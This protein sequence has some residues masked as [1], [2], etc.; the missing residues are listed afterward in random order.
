MELRVALA[1]AGSDDER[2]EQVSLLLAEEL[3]GLDVDSVE[4]AADGDAPAGTRS[5]LAA[6]AGA[7]VVSLRPSPQQL[8]AVV[9][10]VGDWL[11]RSP[12]PRTVKVTI[13]GDTL[14]LTGAS[15]EVQRRV[16]EDWISKH[17]TA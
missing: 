1:E 5:G 6:V 11:R 7:L 4:A 15:D 3:R 9:R 12:T 14:E 17:A 2:L 8:L 16:V 13:D 10:A